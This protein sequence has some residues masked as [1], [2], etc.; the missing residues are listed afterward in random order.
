M[1]TAPRCL[2]CAAWLRQEH[3]RRHHGIRA[4]QQALDHGLRRVYHA[5][6]QRDTAPA[7]QH[8]DIYKNLDSAEPGKFSPDEIMEDIEKNACPGAGACGGMYTA[9]TMSTSIEG[10]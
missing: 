6:L 7:H 8:L 3:A 5:R 1:R 9:N 4:P 2:H 10:E